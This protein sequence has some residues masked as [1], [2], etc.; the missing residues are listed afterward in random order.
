MKKIL[1]NSLIILTLTFSG[2][3]TVFANAGNPGA[4]GAGT[5]GA[6]GAGNPPASSNITIDNP[7]ACGNNCTLFTFLKMIIDNVI[8]PLGAVLAVLA[9][10]YSGF[11]YVMAQGDKSAIEEAHRALLYTAI[12]TAL[13]LGAWVFA[14]V[15]KATVDQLIV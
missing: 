12:G 15:I 14:N 13:L 2:G 6:G 3:V 10:I 11:K 9:F 1:I 8:L 4:G 7:L 5:P